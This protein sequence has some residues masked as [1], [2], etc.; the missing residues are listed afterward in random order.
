[1]QK[2]QEQDAKKLK[3]GAIAGFRTEKK[4]VVF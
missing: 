2:Q 4:E 3:T 1:M